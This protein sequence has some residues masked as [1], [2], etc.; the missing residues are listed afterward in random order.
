MLTPLES[1]DA[2]VDFSS[3]ATPLR[4]LPHWR[5]AKSW[6]EGGEAPRTYVEYKESQ[7]KGLE[8]T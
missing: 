2:T 6:I 5:R 7:H 3:G 1:V 8:K 4:E